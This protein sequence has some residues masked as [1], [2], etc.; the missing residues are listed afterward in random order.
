MD[1]LELESFKD[2]AEGSTD[3]CKTKYLKLL[4]MVYKA[5]CDISSGD[6]GAVKVNLS[7]TTGGALH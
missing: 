1:F 6:T 7:R 2:C 3:K 4:S 5:A